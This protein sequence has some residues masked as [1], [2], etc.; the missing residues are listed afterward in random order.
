MFRSWYK[1]FLQMSTPAAENE[2]R[3]ATFKIPTSDY[4]QVERIAEREDRSV[5]AVLRLA[6]K[7]YLDE[8]RAA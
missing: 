6:V 5:S 3:I 4:Q 1:L 8:R 2:T 7:Q